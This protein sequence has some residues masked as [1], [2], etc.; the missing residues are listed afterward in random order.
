[1]M[2][3][4]DRQ[5]PGANPG[6]KDEYFEQ[7]V[8]HFMD[9]EED[10][11]PGQEN[12][13]DENWRDERSPERERHGDWNSYTRDRRNNNNSD[14]ESSQAS[15][16]QRNRLQSRVKS[17][18]EHMIQ[19]MNAWSQ[20]M[21]LPFSKKSWETVQ[22]FAQHLS[23][24]LQDPTSQTISQPLPEIMIPVKSETE[25][26]VKTLDQ[27]QIGSPPVLSIQPIQ[28]Q[29]AIPKKS[30]TPRTTTVVPTKT[31][32][33]FME[34][35]SNSVEPS[36]YASDN[37]QEE[38]EELQDEYI[39]YLE[40]YSRE[41]ARESKLPNLRPPKPTL[42][43]QMQAV[44]EELSK[45]GI[46]KKD[47]PWIE[48]DREMAP[49][50]KFR[51][52]LGQKQKIL[53][54]A[55]DA[56][57][58]DKKKK[59]GV[60]Y[61]ETKTKKEPLIWSNYRQ[62]YITKEA[63]QADFERLKEK[64]NKLE[65]SRTKQ[66]VEYREKPQSESKQEENPQITYES[67]QAHAASVTTQKFR[68]TLQFVDKETGQSYKGCE[69]LGNFIVSCAHGHDNPKIGQKFNIGLFDI[70]QCK[71][72]YEVELLW[73]NP[74]LDMSIYSVPKT[75]QNYKSLHPT[76]LKENEK[77]VMPY[78]PIN[79]TSHKTASGIAKTHGEHTIITENG[80]SG[81]PITNVE[82]TRVY[83]VHQGGQGEKKDNKWIPFTMD[84]VDAITHNNLSS[85]N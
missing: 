4:F 56:K 5:N 1:M 53:N 3:E 23:I 31:T 20:I 67:E 27:P 59:T 60:V 41:M 44:D 62:K 9:L 64:K 10:Y 35:E 19:N 32:P 73:T 63:K 30:I 46:Q 47:I 68:H 22:G 6:Y 13:D 55:L 48:F 80:A 38:V 24:P 12:D 83:G 54:Q 36:P 37:E 70:D 40:N 72:I 33:T 28:A 49:Q 15:K 75:L 82:R 2:N 39:T 79:T 81:G 29:K 18:E 25:Q 16:N 51:A 50:E 11:L 26:L 34:T 7:L 42:T 45:L 61:A 21:L 74:E 85:L 8:G 14:S 17:L 69:K 58:V 43:M 76:V 71:G 84:I 57:S 65:D 52:I 77:T 78:M 66:K